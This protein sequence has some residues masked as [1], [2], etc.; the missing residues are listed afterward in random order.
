MVKNNFISSGTSNR[1]NPCKQSFRK[2][3]VGK[4][5][6]DHD[7]VVIA[8]DADDGVC[9]LSSLRQGIDDVRLLSSTSR[10]RKL[11]DRRN[12]FESFPPDPPEMV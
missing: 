12:W 10:F 11:K 4:L 6:D 7:G 5:R 8:V 3:F 2:L 1:S 9:K